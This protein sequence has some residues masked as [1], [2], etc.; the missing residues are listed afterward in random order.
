MRLD[1]RLPLGLMF[2]LIGAIL[3]LY[4]VWGGPPAMAR[5]TPLNVNAWCGFALLLFGGSCLALAWRARRR[6][7]S[8]PSTPAGGSAGGAGLP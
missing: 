7:G 3:A 4:G 6:A 5:T 2:L 8:R 1:V